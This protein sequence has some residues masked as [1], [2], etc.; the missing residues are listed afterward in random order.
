MPG[1]LDKAL[2]WRHGATAFLDSTVVLDPNPDW[3]KTLPGSQQPDRQ[4]FKTCDR[5]LARRVKVWNAAASASQQL[6]DGFSQ[7]VEQGRS[8]DVKAL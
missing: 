2:K 1:W 4:D 7:W 3:V 8:A 5:D 6:A